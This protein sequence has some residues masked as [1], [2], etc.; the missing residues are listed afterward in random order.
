M[1]RVIL[2]RQRIHTIETVS[3]TTWEEEQHDVP[4]TSTEPYAVLRAKTQAMAELLKCSEAEAERLI[5]ARC[6]V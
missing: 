4:D 1:R 6:D 2:K 5:L 3:L